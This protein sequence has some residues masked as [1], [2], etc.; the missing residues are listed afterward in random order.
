M[1]DGLFLFLLTAIFFLMRI[2]LD[3]QSRKA[4]LGVA[5][6]GLLTGLAVLVR[7]IWPLIIVTGG[8]FLFCC[9][10]KRKVAWLLLIVFLACAAA[11]VAVWR[12]RNQREAHFS[13]ISN[14]AGA[15]I[16]L[17]LA[18]RVRAEVSG[19]SRYEVSTLAYQEEQ[20]WNMRLSSQEADNEKWRRSKIIFQQHPWLTI[21]SFARSAFEHFIHPSPDVL[22]LV[23]LNF[24]GDTVVLAIFWGGLLLLSSYALLCPIFNPACQNAYIDWRFL[25][26]MLCICGALTLSSG[27]SFGAG[28][29]L[30]APLEA[31]VPL[32]AAVGVVQSVRRFSQVAIPKK[33]R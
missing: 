4:L 21:Y 1:A 29:R 7:P 26:A 28:S 25:L 13:G 33:E 2:V 27:I 30:R 17:Y 10:P 20:Q 16:W 24:P 18:A 3:Y 19:Q 9:G 8:A 15:T 14:I 23:K 11:P 5:C 12:Q 31:I 32:L 6:I 22:Q